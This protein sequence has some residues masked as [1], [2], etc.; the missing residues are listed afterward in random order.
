MTFAAGT[1]TLDIINVGLLVS[2]FDSYEKVE[3][4]PR[5][6]PNISRLKSTKTMYTLFMPDVAEKLYPF[7]AAHYPI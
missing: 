3:L 2:L 4:L 7:G 1:V 5:N 6:I